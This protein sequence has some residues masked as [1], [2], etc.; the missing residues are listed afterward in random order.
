[1]RAKYLEYEQ[2]LQTENFGYSKSLLKKKAK[3]KTREKLLNY[4]KYIFFKYLLADVARNWIKMN[5]N[6]YLVYNGCIHT[7]AW[8][9]SR[10]GL[11]PIILVHNVVNL[12]TFSFHY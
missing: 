10:S 4:V 12:T 11:L 6:V 3:I 5:L 2:T 7:I 8:F 9:K 1:M